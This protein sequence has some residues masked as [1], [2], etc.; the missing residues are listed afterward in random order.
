MIACLIVCLL[1][2]WQCKNIKN[3]IKI[4]GIMATSFANVVAIKVEID[5]SE[6]E[7]GKQNF[8]QIFQSTVRLNFVKKIIL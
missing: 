4:D 3:N 5:D 8:W 7:S 1:D 6:A 2:H